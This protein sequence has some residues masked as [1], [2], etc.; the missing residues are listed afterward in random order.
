MKFPDA[1]ELS[2]SSGPGDKFQD[3]IHSLISLLVFQFK[4]KFKMLLMWLRCELKMW[5]KFAC[6]A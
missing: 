2:S 4:Q 3:C 1:K 5:K 6:N